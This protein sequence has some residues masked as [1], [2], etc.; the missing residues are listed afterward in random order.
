[1]NEVPSNMLTR[2]PR[3]SFDVFCNGVQIT[4]VFGSECLHLLKHVSQVE[5]FYFIFN[6]L[7]NRYFYQS[8]NI[9]TV[10]TE[11]FCRKNLQ[12]YGRYNLEVNILYQFGPSVEGKVK[13]IL[14][15]LEY[16]N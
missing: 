5:M 6:P 12:P 2:N 4:T 15:Q 16:L 8:D 3:L 13:D 9:L 11:G 7:N 10:K 14:L 1:M